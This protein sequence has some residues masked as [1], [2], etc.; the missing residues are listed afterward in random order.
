MGLRSR[1]ITGLVSALALVSSATFAQNVQNF[2]PAQG[3]WNYFSVEGAR[4]AKHLEFVPSLYVN[5]GHNP[6]VERDKDEKIIRKVVEHLVTGNILLD[7]GMGDMFEIGIDVPIHYMTGETFEGES[8]D[9]VTIGDIRIVPKL[10]LFGLAPGTDEKGFGAAFLVDVSV[11]T[12]D[13]EK[14]LSD[15][16]VTVG[17]KLALE[18]RTSGF[19]VAGNVGGRI[20]FDKTIVQ[21]NGTGQTVGALEVGTEL[22]YGLGIGVELGSE[23]LLLLG[24]VF[25]V[26]PLEDIN[27]DSRSKPLEGLL[28]LRIFTDSGA[29]FNIG[30][31][32]GIIPDY[33]SPEF[34]VLGGFTFHKRTDDRDGDG[35]KDEVDQ[36]PDNPEDK[37]DFEDENGCPDPDNDKDGVLDTSDQCPLQPEDKDGFEDENGCPDPDNDQDKILDVDDKC[38]LEPETYNENQDEDGCPDE[39][40]DSDGDGLLDNVDKCPQKP[41]DKDNFEDEDGCPDPDN[42]KDGFL[43]TEDQC[44]LEPENING[45]KDDDGCPDE[46]V[47]KVKVTAEKIEIL[48]KVY[49]ATNKDRIL[50]K[51]FG[52]LDQVATVLIR[53]TNLKK[54]RVEGHTDDRGRD[55]Y[56]L[57]LSQRRAESVMKYLTE[58]G[59]APERLEAVGY[60]E[61]KPIES[62]KTRK[63]RAA[64]RRVEFTIIEQAQVEGVKI[65]NNSTK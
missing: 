57:D 4:T 63:G 1:V 15:D 48:D 9:G 17:P 26:A 24:E 14:F 31:G 28:G 34:R 10:R 27:D 50:K 2:R 64:N 37:D 25:G 58:K 41:E 40:G 65:E 44:P 12:G 16:Q 36:C 13:K 45:V 54:I 30:G 21:P 49:F 20:R 43:D 42:D 46:G 60:G 56:N 33:G 53:Y 19:Q 55:K 3:T 8:Q 6:L 5:Y 32:I 59:V 11:P 51:S 61:E 38:P 52:V 23:S 47:S 29:V 18:F 35:I 62:N 39:I 22:T 7:L